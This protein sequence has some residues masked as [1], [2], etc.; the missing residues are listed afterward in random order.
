MKSRSSPVYITTD[1]YIVKVNLVEFDL[2]ESVFLG[3]GNVPST[4]IVE[5]YATTG[6]GYFFNVKHAPFGGTLNL[7]GNLSKFKE[8]GAKYYKVLISKDGGPLNEIH[9]S[10]NMNLFQ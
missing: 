6:P 7:F 9:P 8:L 1:K 2:S 5:G 3:I 4:K 10:R